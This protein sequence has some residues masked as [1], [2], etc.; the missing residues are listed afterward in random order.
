MSHEHEFAVASD[1]VRKVINGLS[2]SG[3]CHNIRIRAPDPRKHSLRITVENVDGVSMN[4]LSAALAPARIFVRSSNDVGSKLD[5]YFQ[6]NKRRDLKA[7]ES[8][9]WAAALVCFCCFLRIVL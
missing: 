3:A 6:F 8:L 5:L 1:R 2:S 9:A 4:D 7:A